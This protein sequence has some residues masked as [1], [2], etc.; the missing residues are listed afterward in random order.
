MSGPGRSVDASAPNCARKLELQRHA[1]ALAKQQLAETIESIEQ[2]PTATRVGPDAM[3]S[4]RSEPSPRARDDVLEAREIVR[5]PEVAT[6][7]TFSR[8][9]VTPVQGNRS[10]TF[11]VDDHE[12]QLLHN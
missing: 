4:A 11:L 2:L 7:G 9:E 8:H 12:K 1:I 5:R 6:T 3:A 10:T